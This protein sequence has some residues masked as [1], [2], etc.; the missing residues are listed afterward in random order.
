M[1]VASKALW[2]GGGAIAVGTGFAF[3][4]APSAGFAANLG[5]GFTNAAWVGGHALD[6]AGSVAE[7][8]GEAIVDWAVG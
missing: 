3:A 5:T 2:I 6:I 4:A 1:S 7:F 8:G